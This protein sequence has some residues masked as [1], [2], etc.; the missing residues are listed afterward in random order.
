MFN[1]CV[2]VMCYVNSSI[3]TM[4]IDYKYIYNI[5]LHQNKCI[6]N[7]EIDRGQLLYEHGNV[8]A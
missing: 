1:T 5:L 3:Q 7:S 8:D 2:I 6:I 4:F